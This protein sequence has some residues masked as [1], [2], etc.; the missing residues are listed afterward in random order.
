MCNL[1]LPGCCRFR[2]IWRKVCTLPASEDVCQQQQQP[3]ENVYT[4]A[5]S[6]SKILFVFFHLVFFKHLSKYKMLKF[7][8]K[9]EH[10]HISGER[11]S[12]V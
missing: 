7:L 10:K 6:E 4:L 1:L 8:L 9:Y 12:H 3:P 11:K 2:V 5:N